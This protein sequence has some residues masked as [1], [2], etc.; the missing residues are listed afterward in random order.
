MVAENVI[1]LASSRESINRAKE[2]VLS[3]ANQKVKPRR[4][5]I[6][7]GDS[8]KSVNRH[9]QSRTSYPEDD[10]FG[11]RF[12]NNTCAHQLMLAEPQEY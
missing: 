4:G 1:L 3:I 8:G 12:Q 11:R 10:S 9:L 7:V 6:T 2:L 5:V